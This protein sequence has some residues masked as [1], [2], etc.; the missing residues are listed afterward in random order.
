MFNRDGRWEMH[1]L[2][3]GLYRLGAR[4]AAYLR[5]AYVGHLQQ[6]LAVALKHDN[7]P[8][9]RADR[10]ASE[11][12]RDG[13]Q[14]LT[15]GVPVI[16]E[17]EVCPAWSERQRWSCYWLIDPL[18]GTREFIAGT[19]QFCINIALIEANKATLG[20]IYLPLCGVMYIG[21]SQQPA[22]LYDGMSGVALQAQSASR[23]ACLKVLMSRR[24]CL[25]PGMAE[26]M[27]RLQRA[28]PWVLRELRGSAWKF[29][30]LAEGAGHFYPCL[31][32]TS[33]WDT[34]AGQALLESVGGLVLD[35]QGRPLRY[36]RGDSLVN[37]AFYAL[38]PAAFDWRALLDLTG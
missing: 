21:G 8:V 17:E 29:C 33:E 23:S 30:R 1:E 13:L 12:L 16:S 37:P 11:L 6:P 35:H 22:M 28:F 15:P 14:A 34:A 20:A 26:L 31:G 3:P 32:K 7:S 2:T 4:V 9:T 25:Y 18:D 5:E 27:E 38:S 24:A 10:G 36:N 19:G